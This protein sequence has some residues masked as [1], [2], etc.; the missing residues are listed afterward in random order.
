[1]EQTLRNTQF[2]IRDMLALHKANPISDHLEV[3]TYTWGVLPEEH[4]TDNMQDAI[5]RELQWVMAQLK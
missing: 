3:E 5:V 4:K 2:F 1:V